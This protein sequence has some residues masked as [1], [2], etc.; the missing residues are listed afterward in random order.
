M[1]TR[2]LLLAVAI[3][4]AVAVSSLAF[5]FEVGVG[6]EPSI[7]FAATWEISPSFTVVTSL[8]AVFGGAVQTGS[9]TIQ[10]MSYTLG[11]ELRY[12]MH[13]ETLPI[14]PYFGMGAFLEFGGGNTALL[15]APTLGVQI[16]L[17]PGV[18]VF[19]EG[20]ALI[21]I[22]DASRW[23]ARLKLG[24]GYRLGQR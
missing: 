3:A 14:V 4:C 5:G 17:L 8:G 11:V 18:H 1:R 20:A 23:S 24:F 15:M 12:R 9:S 7:S 13:F 6:T 21:P 10:T 16:N 2:T 19:V 22:H